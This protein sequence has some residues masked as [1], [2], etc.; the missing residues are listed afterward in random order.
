MY[1]RLLDNVKRLLHNLEFILQETCQAG[2]APIVM[3]LLAFAKDHN[4]PPHKLISQEVVLAAIDCNDL[5]TFQALAAELPQIVT[6]KLGHGGT[7]LSEAIRTFNH[8]LRGYSDLRTPLVAF[9]LQN[10][11]DPSGRRHDRHLYTASS[12][13]SI[14]K[15]DLLLA[16]GATIA[17]VGVAYSAAKGG[18]IH[19]LESLFRAG[20]E[21]NERVGDVAAR[22]WYENRAL[23]L[24]IAAETAMHL[25]VRERRYETVRWRKEHGTS[26]DLEDA[27]SETPRKIAVDTG[28]ERMLVIVQ[29]L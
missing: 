22:E 8:D 27:R 7:P 6:F 3:F 17:G 12:H 23:R 18:R 2:N 13:G 21:L 5:A 14:N 29:E 16:H 20:A 11:A 1:T 15:V 9:L 10:G 25:A 19:V 28:D 4:I 26:L 24:Q